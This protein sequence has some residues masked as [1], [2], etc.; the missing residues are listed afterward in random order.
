MKTHT[1]ASVRPVTIIFGLAHLKMYL[2]I[3][4][5]IY[6]FCIIRFSIKGILSV[7]WNETFAD[8]NRVRVMFTCEIVNVE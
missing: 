3:Y 1:H 5:Y 7:L 6:I 4:M 8:I 2:Y